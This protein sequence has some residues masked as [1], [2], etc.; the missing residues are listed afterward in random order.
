MIDF[1]NKLVYIMASS[2]ASPPT[3]EKLYECAQTLSNAKGLVQ[4]R[5]ASD[6]QLILSGVRGDAQTK[7][8]SSQFIARFFNKFPNLANASLDALLDLCEDDDVNIRKQAIKDLPM[9]CRESKDFLPKIADVLSQ[10]LQTQDPAE[11]TVIQN[12]LMSLFRKEAKGTLIG[13]F[14]QIKTG[15]DIVR[16]RAIQFLFVKIKTE[17]SELLNK[18]AENHLLEEIKLCMGEDCTSD[19][20]HTFM[21]ILGMTS[22]PKTVSGQVKI[23]DMISKMVDFE[24]ETLDLDDEDAVDRIIQCSQAAAPFF[25]QQVR[26]TKYVDYMCCRVL[27]LWEGI[28]TTEQTQIL[29]ILAEL[30]MFTAHISNPIVAAENVYKILLEHLPAPLDNDSNVQESEGHEP[31]KIIAEAA[32]KFEFTKVEC[33]LFIFHTVGKQAP[34]F[35][36]DNLEIL[37]EFKS[38]LQYFALG[39]QGYIRKLRELLSN[40]SAAELNTKENKLKATALKSVTNINSLI[41]DLFHAPPSYKTNIIVSWR[42]QLEDK[43][44]VKRKSIT[45]DDRA[46]KKTPEGASSVKKKYVKTPVRIMGNKGVYQPPQGKYSTGLGLEANSNFGAG[47]RGG[48]G[49]RPRGRGRVF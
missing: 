38:R 15:G 43:A 34:Q 5:N 45:F 35:L 37:K 13:L 30:C 17:G 44:G 42:P 48:K 47:R 21:S 2:L 8:L 22:L 46:Q 28:A 32:S 40:K 19:E 33:L 36:T 18:E 23:V 29:T 12:S 10:L 27:P 1:F 24:K 6:Y 11:L 3:L 26:S 9:L 25:S 16:K 14:S 4:N 31:S 49:S 39:T 7:R 20:F 41:K